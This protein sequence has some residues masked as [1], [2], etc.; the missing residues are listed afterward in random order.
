MSKGHTKERGS[1]HTLVRVLVQG[2]DV[3]GLDDSGLA[4]DD[5]RR[6]GK[7]ALSLFV[8]L[9]PRASTGA[10]VFRCRVIH[11]R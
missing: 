4:L 7:V 6:L 8:A 1:T 3:G 5:T 9:E 11:L 10:S 2:V